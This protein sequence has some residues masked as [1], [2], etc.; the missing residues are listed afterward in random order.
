MHTSRSRGLLR[1]LVV[2]VAAVVAVTAFA[3]GPAS[4]IVPTS[5]GSAPGTGSL[6]VAGLAAEGLTGKGPASSGAGAEVHLLSQS[7]GTARGGLVPAATTCTVSISPPV[8]AGAASAAV[9]YSVYCDQE[10]NSIYGII[11]IFRGN[12]STPLGN[13]IDR[14][15]L[16]RFGG[17]FQIQRACATG[18]LY[19]LMRVVVNFKTGSPTTIDRTFAGPAAAITC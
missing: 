1:Q 3:A 10:V 15:D 6:T 11:G 17:G 13:T 8:R 16:G 4:A 5:S 9:D 14:F 18:N 2:A 12:E 7:G 19:A